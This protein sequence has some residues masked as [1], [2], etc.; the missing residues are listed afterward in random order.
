MT[1]QHMSA[2]SWSTVGQ[3][4][5]DTSPTLRQHFTFT[6]KMYYNFH[7]MANHFWE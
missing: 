6:F 4:T 2:M 7:K 3:L 5:A 1:N